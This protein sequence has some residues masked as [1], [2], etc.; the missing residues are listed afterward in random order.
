M[1]S[2]YDKHDKNPYFFVTTE[3]N[4]MGGGGGGGGGF[5]Q[6]AG[7]ISYSIIILK[8]IQIDIQFW[9]LLMLKV[10]L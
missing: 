1:E 9:K 6:N 8:H 4:R 7:N 5:R 2:T 3:P 10:W